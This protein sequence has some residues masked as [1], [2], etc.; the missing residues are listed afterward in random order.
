M[1]QEDSSKVSLD[2]DQLEHRYYDSEGT[3]T[4]RVIKAPKLGCLTFSSLL[5]PILNM[6]IYQEPILIKQCM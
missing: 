2:F 1:I 3:D 5:F 6:I 4:W